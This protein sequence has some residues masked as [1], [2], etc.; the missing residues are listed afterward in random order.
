MG[1]LSSI[2]KVL[3]KGAKIASG[4]LGSPLGGTALDLAG[5]YLADRRQSEAAIDNREWQEQ[6]YR[7][8]LAQQ[9][10]ENALS[11]ERTDY[12]NTVGLD[13]AREQQSEAVRQ[14]DAMRSLAIND[15]TQRHHQ[16]I[17]NL[18]WDAK[19]AGI[20]PLY[21]MGA[22]GGGGVGLSPAGGGSFGAGSAATAALPGQSVT[23]SQPGDALAGAISRLGGRFSARRAAKAQ[24]QQNRLANARAARLQNLQE[25]HINAQIQGQELENMARA[26]EIARAA[27]KS[28]QTRPA[29]QTTDPKKWPTEKVPRQLMRAPSTVY[30]R[31]DGSMGELQTPSDMDEIRQAEYVYREVVN[32]VSNALVGRHNKARFRKDLL[33]SY[34]DPHRRRLVRS[35]I[36]GGR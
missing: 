35:H 9:K 25:R 26:S 3:S 10:A 36:R 28:N 31:K 20:H 29:R 34:N 13:F 27:Q 32:A 17:R 30:R 33:A 6:L 23:G 24:L 21:A 22:S 19:Q 8:N 11:R 12:W 5:G 18:V 7:E 15:Y 14:F 4:F 2:G 1:F 16:R